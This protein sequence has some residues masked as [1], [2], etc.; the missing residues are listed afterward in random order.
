MGKKYSLLMAPSSQKDDWQPHGRSANQGR[1][2]KLTNKLAVLRLRA[3]STE[4][5]ILHLC[6]MYPAKDLLRAAIEIW[7]ITADRYFAQRLL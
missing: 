3:S 2:L 4:T 6:C 7:A 1:L 5:A